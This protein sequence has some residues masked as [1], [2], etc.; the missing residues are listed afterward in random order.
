M[1]KNSIYQRVTACQTTDMFYHFCGV[2][3]QIA[4]FCVS[5]GSYMAPRK[6]RFGR[7]ITNL[8]TGL[9][10]DFEGPKNSQMAPKTLT[11]VP[12]AFKAVDRFF[13]RAQMQ[14]IPILHQIWL[15]DDSQKKSSD[16]NPKGAR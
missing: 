6:R 12:A 3:Y 16:L 8:L 1:A 11:V 7:Q 5:L 14:Q 10:R 2:L 15:L 13:V 9:L 4:A